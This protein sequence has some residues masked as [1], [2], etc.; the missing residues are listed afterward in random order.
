MDKSNIIEFDFTKKAKI[1]ADY[2]ELSYFKEY[3]IKT[4]KG[5]KSISNKKDLEV[6]YNLIKNI[7]NCTILDIGANKGYYALLTTL[8]EDLFVYSFE[9]LKNTYNNWLLQNLKLNNV[10][11]KVKTFNFGLLNERCEKTLYYDNTE[12][13]T[14]EKDLEKEAKILKELERRPEA[15]TKYSESDVHFEKLDDIIEEDIDQKIDVVKID[16]EG[17]ELLTL[18]GGEKFFREQKPLLFVEIE[19]RHCKR[20]GTTVLEV[21]NYLMSLGYVR[22]EQHNKINYVCK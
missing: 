4:I 8:K 21:I 12:N 17:S 7:P 14:I 5:S 22:F 9:P 1:P 19:E 15:W 6:F 20:F 2:H 11:N 13:A 3:K 16:V 18:Q 10:R